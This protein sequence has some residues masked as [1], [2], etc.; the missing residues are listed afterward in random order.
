MREMN[1]DWII[2]P[3]LIDAVRRKGVT[4]LV[5]AGASQ[6]EPAKVPAWAT[7]AEF[8]D[9]KLGE[10]RFL[11][12]PEIRRLDPGRYISEHVQDNPSLR[13]W[14]IDKIEKPA[15]KTIDGSKV[16]SNLHRKI[17]HMA[18]R[19][20]GENV[21]VLT[22]NYDLL[23]E[24]AAEQ[25][26]DW[27]TPLKRWDGPK[28]GDAA[29]ARGIFHMHGTLKSRESIVLTMNDMICHYET[30]GRRNS[31][32][33][34]EIFRERLILAIGYGFR[35]PEIKTI[36]EGIGNN[37]YGKL[38]AIIEANPDG[39]RPSMLT[40]RVQA[41]MYK[42]GQH[43][44]VK[45]ILDRIEDMAGTGG[46]V[47]QAKTWQETGRNGPGNA[48]LDT[49]EQI[50]ALIKS[51]DANLDHFLN[52]TM[53][54]E[55]A[56]EWICLE[57]LEAGLSGVF[58][59]A[60]LSEGE[61]KLYRWL[62]QNLTGKRLRKVIWAKA[63][64]GGIMHPALQFSLGRE[65]QDKE[66]YFSI[67]DLRLGIGF[68]CSQGIIG[69]LNDSVSSMLGLIVE[70]VQKMDPSET[71]SGLEVFRLLTEVVAQPDQHWRH[72]DHEYAE[73][74]V[75]LNA[76]TRSDGY[77]IER[78]WEKIGTR[79]VENAP[80]ELWD[81]ASAALRRQ[82][83]I[84]DIGGGKKNSFNRWH[85]D[86]PAIEKLSQLPDWNKGGRYVLLDAARRGLSKMG[87][88]PGS[89]ERWIANVDRA[90]KEGSPLLRRIAVDTVR[91]T[92]HWNS[93]M[94]LAWVANQDRMN[95]W[96]TWRERRLLVK[97]AWHGA[98]EATKETAANSIARMVQ[99]TDRRK[100]TREET[101]IQ[102]ADMIIWLKEQEIDHQA[103]E[104]ELNSLSK[105]NPHIENRIRK[106]SQSTEGYTMHRFQQINPWH[107]DELIS[108]WKKRGDDALDELMEWFEQIDHPDWPVG[109]NEE[110]V[111][112]AIEAVV[113]KCADYGLAF[114]RKLSEPP[115]SSHWGWK[116]LTKAMPQHLDSSAGRRWLE[117]TNW[118]AITEANRKVEWEEMLYTASK[119][120]WEKEWNNE[121]VEILYITAKRAIQANGKRMEKQKFY[122]SEL[123]GVLEQAINEPEGKAIQAILFLWRLQAK[124]E[125]TCLA[126]TQP[127]SSEMIGVLENLATRGD[128]RIQEWATVILAQ[129]FGIVVETAEHVL[130]RVVHKRLESRDMKWRDVVWDGLSYSNHWN[131]HRVMDSLTEAMRRDLRE[132]DNPPRVS[133]HGTEK[134]QVASKYGYTLAVKVWGEDQE[135]EGWKIGALPEKR[136]Q[137][138]VAKICELFDRNEK[139]HA[140][141]WRKLIV[142][143]WDDIKEVG[144][145]RTTEEEQE[146]LLV[147]FRHL[148][149]DDQ[150]EFLTKFNTGPPVS[151]KTLIRST[152]ES[153]KFKNLEAT[154]KILLHCCNSRQQRDPKMEGFWDWHRILNMLQNEWRSKASST[155]RELID[156][157]LAIHGRNI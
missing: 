127:K 25:G 69:G 15:E 47:V 49:W 6:D 3:E 133:R 107:A 20:G 74:G 135:Y 140:E 36:I 44:E 63:I 80:E 93:D 145:K 34:T 120:A 10:T 64:A 57:M 92:T 32:Y 98:Q 142:P 5:G 46:A 30:N 41:I 128:I 23:L 130:K 146:A 126:S 125:K 148:N 9:K 99:E 84:T 77:R 144:K 29:A 31:K 48:T 37:S 110:G 26:S 150:N 94:K 12:E 40:D 71:E 60:E 87:S 54:A 138:V 62:A 59:I 137:A 149:Y 42:Y 1:Q 155:E 33:L 83:R 95:D 131:N 86:L 24:A 104:L 134:D 97:E 56:D 22:T 79:L 129:N 147:C 154:L 76:V 112:R 114:S 90:I 124:R 108:E 73:A 118:E 153:S 152:D 17:M 43:D 11:Y 111:A 78:A 13:D 65:L 58:R 109:P 102:R 35:D 100:Q 132:Q 151:P 39:S 141:G 66:R 2:P 82:Q 38:Y 85:Y 119:L 4:F 156:R 115:L 14:I 106:E 8:L 139:M 113:A 19:W 61:Q 157:L 70:R 122:S 67:E 72:K 88:T 68:L 91:T 7:L 27:L 45:K 121:T 105:K 116:P 136:R 143:L 81:T 51:G 55:N 52:G 16:P 21:L 28:A 101:D 89:E 50:G 117:E 18:S 123:I 103:M 53:E 96:H 75:S